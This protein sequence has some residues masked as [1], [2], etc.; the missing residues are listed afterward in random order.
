[1]INFI[2]G[3]MLIWNERGQV[4]VYGLESKEAITI[5]Y[6]EDSCSYVPKSCFWKDANTS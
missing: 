1:M 2:T 5:G 3:E 6:S 4:V